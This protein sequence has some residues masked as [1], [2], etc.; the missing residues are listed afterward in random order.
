[1]FTHSRIFSC[2]LDFFFRMSIPMLSQLKMIFTRS[3]CQYHKDM[4]MASPK[5]RVFSCRRCSSVEVDYI[6]IHMDVSWNGGTPKSSILSHFNRIFHYKPSIGGD[7]GYFW[8][9]PAMAQKIHWLLLSHSNINQQIFTSYD[10]WIPLRYQHFH[11]HQPMDFPLVFSRAPLWPIR[12]RWT[13]L[14]WWFKVTTN[15]GRGKNRVFSTKLKQI[16]RNWKLGTFWTCDMC[17]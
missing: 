12:P 1:M 10:P 9:I 3:L 16:H 7:L 5:T 8:G 13:L 14:T 2:F 11:R 4:K 15:K 17:I 6:W